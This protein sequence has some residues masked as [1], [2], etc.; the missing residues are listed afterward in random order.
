MNDDT[1]DQT[2][3][4]QIPEWEKEKDKHAYL[5]FLSGPLMGKIHLL[6]EGTIRI[7]RGTDVDIPINDLGI[8][9]H[10]VEIHYHRGKTILRDLGST[11]GTYLNGQRV[12][13]SELQDGDRI[14]V[15]SST[16]MKYAYQDKIEN[17]FHEEL[18]KMA[19]VDALTGA[20]NKRY[21]EERIREEFSYCLRNQVPLSLLM[22]DIDLFK[23]IN[24]T[25]G[26]PAGDFV[27][28]RIA[29][30][31][32]SIVRNED[33]IARYGGEE[34]MI[35]LK[36]TDPSGALML[37][38]RL[39]RLIDETVFE[40]EGKKIHVT[41]SIGIATLMGQNLPDWETMIKTA[42]TLLY[43]S[44]NSGRNRVSA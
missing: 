29:T 10:H 2:V 18:Y 39:R 13:E 30:L 7:G 12:A 36:T 8:S 37:A 22:F 3:V 35:V 20:Y 38:E 1:H 17:I 44:K 34:F 11:N 26:H 27:L 33:L 23:Q 19:V 41:I 6:E 15:S 9:R 40:F 5:V 25:H 24:D 14:Q 16:I 4:T 32:R 31:A 21:F 42:D 43:Q 28:S